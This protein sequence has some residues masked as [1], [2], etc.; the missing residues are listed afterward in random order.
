MN[1]ST[2]L[3]RVLCVLCAAALALALTACGSKK[4]ATTSTDGVSHAPKITDPAIIGQITDDGYELPFSYE[5]GFK[6]VMNIVDDTQYETY[7]TSDDGS[8]R[9]HLTTSKSE[10]EVKAFFE[11]YFKDLQKVKPKLETD[12]SQ[13]YYDEEKR[14]V[15]F[16]F[17]VWTAD[18]K[19]NYQ[20]CATPCDDLSQNETWQPAE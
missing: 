11:D 7:T 20:L 18:G 9:F 3:K 6:A 14:I 16:N 10:D 1:K 17:E 19:T 15:V 13:G 2:I 8:M 12:H 5:D 4:K